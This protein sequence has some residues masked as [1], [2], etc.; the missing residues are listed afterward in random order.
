MCLRGITV[1]R[2]DV[3]PGGH[4][5]GSH[6]AQSS[7]DE[8]LATDGGPFSVHRSLFSQ[9]I[10]HRAQL[11]VSASYASTPTLPPRA[12]FSWPPLCFHGNGEFTVSREGRGI[13]QKRSGAFPQP[14]GVCQVITSTR[15][16][17]SIG[18]SALVSPGRQRRP[19]AFQRAASGQSSFITATAKKSEACEALWCSGRPPQLTARRFWDQ[20]VV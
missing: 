5:V 3:N 6:P 9:E 2:Q 11:P 1:P 7:A 8:P 19:P 4:G 15:T 12:I 10:Q 16:S 18:C 13:F 20:T 14:S 17:P